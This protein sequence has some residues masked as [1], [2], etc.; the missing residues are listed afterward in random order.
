VIPNQTFLHVVEKQCS[1]A[2]GTVV[3]QRCANI[4]MNTVRSHMTRPYTVLTPMTLQEHYARTNGSHS[5][6]ED[7]DN[8]EDAND[9]STTIP[10][11]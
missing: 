1:S 3:D 7:V 5:D 10:Q 6:D 9:G 4:I 11:A 2:L 8:N